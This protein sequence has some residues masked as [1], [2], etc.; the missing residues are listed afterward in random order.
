M[1]R[2]FYFI[3]PLIFAFTLLPRAATIE[4]KPEASCLKCHE[5]L[6]VKATTSP[7]QHSV[8]K[9]SCV[10]CHVIQDSSSKRNVVLW[11]STFQ[12]EGMIYIGRLSEGKK[13]RAG[14]EALD[15]RGKKS[16]PEFIEIMPE[17]T[18]K[19]P[20]VYSKLK[21][22]SDVRLEEIKK[23]IFAEAV[24]SWTTDVPATSEVEYRLGNRKYRKAAASDNLFT[25]RHKVI[26]N[27]LKHN[28]HYIYRVISRDTAGNML[29]SEEYSFDTSSKFAPVSIKKDT[30]SLQAE[31]TE[32]TVLRSDNKNNYYLKVSANKS[33]QFVVWLNEIEETEGSRPCTSFKQTRYSTIDACIICHPQDSSHPVGV[34]SKNPKVI[35]SDQLPTIEGGLIT[36]VSCHYPHGG[37]KAYFVRLDFTEEICVKCHQA[38][39]N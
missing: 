26:L 10:L 37:S 4:K 34:R 24:I 6:Y 15:S 9:E 14:V 39:Y 1:I 8:V 30:G 11:S 20:Q 22:L 27:G 33:A 32:L 35:V 5:D 3:V 16:A 36:C 2:L 7:Y 17:N 31:I 23:R 38:Y 18:R 25:Q 19:F 13:Y 29:S 28:E 12:T 21:K